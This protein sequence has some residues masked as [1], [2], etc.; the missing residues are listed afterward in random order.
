MMG[1]V[2]GRKEKIGTKFITNFRSVIELQKK[3]QGEKER[4]GEETDDRHHHHD[5]TEKKKKDDR[6]PSFLF[7]VK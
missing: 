4:G 6:Q 7:G 1:G 2:I 3:R 5:V